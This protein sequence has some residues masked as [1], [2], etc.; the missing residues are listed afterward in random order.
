M[1]PEDEGERFAILWRDRM[2]IEKFARSRSLE[3]V[4]EAYRSCLASATSLTE[5]GMRAQLAAMGL[6]NDDIEDQIER[7]RDM[8]AGFRDA[9]ARGEIVWESPTRVGYRNDHGQELIRKTG[10]PGTLPLQKVYVLKCGSC[11]HEYGANGSDVHTRRC[12]ACQDGAA[13]LPIL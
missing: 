1:M 5:A 13:G 2:P 8:Q 12:P 10:L 11:S 7:A 6:P 4:R 3:E 9:F